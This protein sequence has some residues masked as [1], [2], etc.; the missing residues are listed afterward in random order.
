MEYSSRKIKKWLN[1][2]DYS[3]LRHAFENGNLDNRREI[4]S[5]LKDINRYEEKQILLLALTDRASSI[6][7]LALSKLEKASLSVE[8]QKIVDESKPAFKPEV[9]KTEKDNTKVDAIIGNVRY[10]ND[11]KLIETLAQKNF[12][13]AEHEQALLAEVEKRGGFDKLVEAAKQRK[14]ND[15][16]VESGNSQRKGIF[17][18]ASGIVLLSLGIVLS[19]ISPNTIFT[20]LID[21]GFINLV[22]GAIFYMNK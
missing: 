12:R 6:S 21:V 7:Q 3:T 18:L 15:I 22:L 20:G 2:H 17:N 16:Q 10:L 9:K 8:E 1:L 4:I 19:I 14:Q 13:N 11:V 5:N